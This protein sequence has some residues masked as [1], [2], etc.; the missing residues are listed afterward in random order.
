MRDEEVVVDEVSP[1]VILVTSNPDTEHPELDLNNIQITAEPTNP[2]APNG[3]TKVQI[4][5]RV[6]DN[7]SGYNLASL[8]LRD[9]QGIEHNY[10][11]YN[12]D[13]WSLFPTGETSEWQTY[14]RDILLP[15]GS[16]P[17]TWGLME[18]TIYDRA[19]NFKSY[20][21]TEIV[22]FDIEK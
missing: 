12:D 6:R 16:P 8:S 3:E 19:N 11:V 10:G 2:S 18:M 14:T 22:H 13:T 9:P 7:I 1:E 5:F 20:D 17:G 15:V 4:T 21:F